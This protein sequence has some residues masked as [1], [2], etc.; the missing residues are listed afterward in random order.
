MNNSSNIFIE[1]ICKRDTITA[2]ANKDIVILDPKTKKIFNIL[3]GQSIQGYG[4]WDEED[5]IYLYIYDI[6]NEEV[7]I[8]VVLRHVDWT[9]F[10]AVKYKKKD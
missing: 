2:Y 3:E 1:Q 10:V 9:F 8:D 5:G 6:L 7:G 4:H